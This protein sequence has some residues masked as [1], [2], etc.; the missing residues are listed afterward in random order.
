[1]GVVLLICL[2]NSSGFSQSYLITNFSGLRRFG[3]SG[4][5]GLAS[6][7]HLGNPMCVYADNSGNIF[8]SDWGNSR[9]REV[10]IYG[11]INTI[12]GNGVYG[13][14]GDGGPA[15]AAELS[16]PMGI[17]EDKYKNIYVADIGNER[18][19][20]IDTNGII[21]TYAGNGAYGF[22]GDG[23]IA[24]LASFEDP[25][26]ICGD[27]SGNIYIA[28]EFNNRIR[29]IDKNGFITTFAGNGVSGYS[30]D[31]GPSKS[32]EFYYPAG[33]SIDNSG[34]ILVADENNNCIRKVNSNGIISTIVGNGVLGFSGD[35]GLASSAELFNPAG[36]AVDNIGNIFI[37]DGFNNRVRK[38]DTTGIISTI[39]GTG[40]SGYSG[41]GDTATLANIHDPISISA[42]NSGNIY[43]ATEFNNLVQ[44][45]TAVS[46]IAKQPASITVY[47]NPSQGVFT[48]DVKNFT[49]PLKL[50]VYNIVGQKI[51]YV[52]L[53]TEETVINLSTASS[54]IYFYR[55]IT[56]NDVV[57]GMGKLVKF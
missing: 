51:A 22:S 31:G 5:G 45:L 42:D 47:P 18:I 57:F 23:G 3:F 28:D 27:A 34:N 38:I 8:I 24:T 10:N 14:S 39:A 37:T 44:K 6:N 41:V 4:D 11:I 13:F 36:V 49:A 20:K 33:V 48:V 19:R 46:E 32:A 21:S 52:G 9:L 43:F 2:L 54:G 30:G 7:A 53:N 29:R 56:S 16:G 17:F 50:E 12:A 35:G 26:G 25:A 1:M 15:I 55:V 40:K